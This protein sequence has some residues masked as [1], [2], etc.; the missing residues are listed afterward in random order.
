[1]AFVLLHC[2]DGKTF[3]PKIVRT[4]DIS[5]VEGAT[6]EAIARYID[7]W[8]DPVDSTRVWTKHRSGHWFYGGID[9]DYALPPEMLDSIRASCANASF[10]V[11][12]TGS[13]TLVRESLYEIAD[14]LGIPT[15]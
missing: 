13:N 10:V 3:Q 2:F 14:L 4:D 15:L 11:G 6:P 1:M 9:L 5:R 12:T 8:T 7:T